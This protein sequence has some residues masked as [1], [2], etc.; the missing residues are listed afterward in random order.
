MNSLPASSKASE[1]KMAPNDGG[2]GRNIISTGFE[3]KSLDALPEELRGPIAEFVQKHVEQELAPAPISKM[4]YWFH[5]GLCVGSFLTIFG[6]LEV[7]RFI[8]FTREKMFTS[9]L[10]ACFALIG[11][12]I[13]TFTLSLIL[14]IQTRRF[15]ISSV[16]V[17]MNISVV[18]FW[19]LEGVVHLIRFAV[20]VQWLVGAIIASLYGLAFLFWIYW[21]AR[22]ALPTTLIREIKMVTSAILFVLVGCIFA[23]KAWTKNDHRTTRFAVLTD[24]M[25]IPYGKHLRP[26]DDVLVK[27][28]EV[29]DDAKLDSSRIQE[30]D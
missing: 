11:L 26:I 2:Q 18:S 22:K 9:F 4:S 19:L 27:L 1:L 10:S 16:F 17:A 24:M 14:R 3:N 28:N 20:P 23:Y 5:I 12:W 29:L 15:H 30:T 8:N 6:I 7:V 25:V 21:F 13:L